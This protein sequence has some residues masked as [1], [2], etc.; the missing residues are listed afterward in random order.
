[1]AK[2]LILLIM[3][4]VRSLA[5]AQTAIA[6]GEA[7]Y[8]YGPETSQQYACKLAEE[9]AKL[10][11][12]AAIFGQALSSE[13]QQ[14]CNFTSG[15]KSD[16]KCEFNRVT[17]TLIEG[18]IKNIKNKNIKEELR[19]G[20]KACM[21]SLDAEIVIPSKK[22]DPNFEVKLRTKQNVY[23]VGDVFALEIE[24]TE[25]AHIAVFNWL[26]NE[27][28]QVYRIIN[29][30]IESRSD[31]G[32]LGKQV[33]GKIGVN[34]TLMASWSDAYTDSKRLYD[35][36]FI[37]IASKNPYKWLSAYSID[38]FKDKLREIPIDDRRVVKRGYQL[39]K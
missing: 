6:H 7:E 38:E 14:F 11:A 18:D 37:V 21:V 28:N 3:T 5:N 36:W 35:E 26:P 31:S 12:L 23:R 2:I 32:Y 13:E 20:A 19:N 1:M 25:P 16:S 15:N 8:L 24:S 33:N 34:Y 22:P 10:N 4:M 39:S 17:W 29:P 30:G 9:K 27:N